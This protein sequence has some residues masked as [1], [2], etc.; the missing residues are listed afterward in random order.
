MSVPAGENGN[1]ISLQMAESQAQ[2]LLGDSGKLQQILINLIGNAIK[3]TE[4]GS[5]TLLVSSKIDRV[6]NTASL[7]FV[8][9]DTGIGIAPERHEE[10]FQAFTQ[11]DTSIARQYGGI[12]LGLAICDRLVVAMGGNM[13]LESAPGAGTSIGFDVEMA[14]CESMQPASSLQVQ[15]SHSAAG[16]N[17]LMV[18][19]DATNRMVTNNY[20]QKLGH[21]V[22]V[23]KSGEQAITVLNTEPLSLVL[24]DIS[25]PGIDGLDL[26]KLIRGHVDTDISDIPVIAMSAHVFTEEVDQYLGAGMNGFLG[27]PF[28][29]QDLDNV[30]G[31]VVDR[32]STS[33]V[34][35]EPT[36]E[37]DDG[38]IFDA[39][40]VDQ[41]VEKLGVDSVDSML[42]SFLHSGRDQHSLL[43]EAIDRKALTSVENIAH[44][45]RGAAG[46]FGLY[47]LCSLLAEIET[48]ARA[49]I[50]V[51]PETHC[52]LQSDY[53]EAI[54]ALNSYMLRYKAD[55][56]HSRTAP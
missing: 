11:V 7:R 12:G 8:V 25:L 6:A 18:E 2:T 36:R 42:E 41:D 51:S 23:A 53:D 30:I 47:R 21:R 4:N 55:S 15:P 37:T 54:V 13:Q 35:I 5:I 43:L 52:R 16:L 24:L 40:V 50:A 39:S 17:V 29:L 27:K 33:F 31:Q 14:L 49:G 1:S 9:K 10:I 22:L 26:L 19:D 46:N 32:S 56:R 28:S 44:K 34:S 3:F 20:L 38:V 48:Q 45:L